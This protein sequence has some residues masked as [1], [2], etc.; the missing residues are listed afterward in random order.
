[1]RYKYGYHT[2]GIKY[3]GRERHL[4]GMAATRIKDTDK[5]PKHFE[6]CLKFVKKICFDYLLLLFAQK[7]N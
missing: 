1:M 6:M 5:F 4:S 7:S 2:S 3:A